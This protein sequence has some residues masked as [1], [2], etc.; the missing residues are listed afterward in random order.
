[1]GCKRTESAF[2]IFVDL[3]FLKARQIETG[4]K[5]PA[6]REQCVGSE[7]STE[8]GNV[9][10]LLFKRFLLPCLNPFLYIYFQSPENNPKLSNPD[11]N[12]LESGSHVVPDIKNPGTHVSGHS[13]TERSGAS[14]NP[15]LCNG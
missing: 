6:E 12:I 1:M 4:F 14:A 2:N 5:S 3:S 13:W 15:A 11:F 7:W 8:A 9:P 10:E